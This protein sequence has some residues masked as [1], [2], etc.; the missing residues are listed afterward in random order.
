MQLFT[1]R[2]DLL[3][4]LGQS[5]ISRIRY[6]C[7]Y[8]ISYRLRTGAAGLLRRARTIRQ[9][10]L[11]GGDRRLVVCFPLLLGVL[12]LERAHFTAQLID[13]EYI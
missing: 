10:Q 11:L 13:P 8:N 2:E 6:V 4:V 9:R 12:D 1:Q 7:E 5:L 3:V